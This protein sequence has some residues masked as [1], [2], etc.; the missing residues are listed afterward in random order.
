[1]TERSYRPSVKQTQLSGF[2]IPRSSV[3]R[4]L[5]RMEELKLQGKLSV[6]IDYQNP[7][8][9]LGDFSQNNLEE[10]QG[11]VTYQEE[12]SVPETPTQRFDSNQLALEVRENKEENARNHRY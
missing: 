4:M 11:A 6:K 7:L 9:L 1:M 2:E 10:T 5:D 3:Y 12:E 8:T